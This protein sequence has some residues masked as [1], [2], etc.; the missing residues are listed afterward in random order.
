MIVLDTN[1]VSELMRPEPNPSVVEWADAQQIKTLFVTSITMSEILFGVEALPAGKRKSRLSAFA[2]GL[3]GIFEDRVL[4]FDLDAAILYAP[5]AA[6]ARRQ[7]LGISIA[8]GY[9]AAITA[10]HGFVIATRDTAPFA[11][12][13]LE[14]IDPWAAR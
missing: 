12:V 10:A 6:T 9:I 1:V 3:A 2:S 11:S 14:V 4:S 13:G 7:G 8:D 5:M